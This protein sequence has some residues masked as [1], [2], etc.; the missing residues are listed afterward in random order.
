M[1]SRIMEAEKDILWIQTN[2][3]LD[4]IDLKQQICQSFADFKDKNYMAKSNNNDLFIVKDDGYL[5]CI[6][7][8]QHAFQKLDVPRVS[9]AHILSVAIDADNVLWIFTSDNDT[10]SYRINK[11]AENITLTPE[12]LFKHQEN[13]YGHSRKSV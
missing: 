8:G 13:C 3:G 4:R 1:I 7:Q 10:R 11:A 6:P 5:Y 2:Y 9:F 12:N